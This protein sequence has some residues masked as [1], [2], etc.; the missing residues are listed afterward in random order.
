VDQEKL[1]TSRF[2]TNRVSFS[3]TLDGKYKEIR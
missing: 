2:V 1:G 3:E